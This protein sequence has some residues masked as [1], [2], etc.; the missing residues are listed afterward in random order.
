MEDSISWELF[1]KQVQ[2]IVLRVQK[3]ANDENIS[4]VAVSDILNEYG[5]L[6]LD[7][8]KYSQDENKLFSELNE[9]FTGIIETL[10]SEKS[11]LVQQNKR[12]SDG[13]GRSIYP[14]NYIYQDVIG[15]A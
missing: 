14:G 5:L 1:K 10:N 3:L 2:D 8:I 6:I 15:T 7:I 4:A 9:T 12:L 11:K 13:I